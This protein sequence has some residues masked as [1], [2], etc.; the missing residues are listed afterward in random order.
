MWYWMAGFPA[1]TYV[2]TYRRDNRSV[3][4]QELNLPP[5]ARLELRE[6]LRWNALPDNRFY[7]YDYYKDN[8]STRVRDAIDR[9][10]GGAIAAHTASLPTGKSYR[11]HT[12]RLTANDPPIFTGL[13][14]ALGPA[15]DRPISAWE[16]MFLPMALRDHVRRVT[17]Q[18]PDGARVPL[19]ASERTLFISTAPQPPDAPPSW[20]QWY[21]LIGTSLGA[22]GALLGDA[23]QRRR[24]AR[25][26]LGVL[27]LLWGTIAGLAGVVLAV[28]WGFTD[29]VMAYRNENLFQLNPLVLVLAAL[30]PLGLAGWRRM[31]RWARM[32]ALGVAA[33]SAAGFV[34]QA[35][36]G[37]D[38]V[39]GQVIAL[40]LPVHLG[41]ALG[42]RRAFQAPG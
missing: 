23:A 6:F 14:L 12:Q 40:A 8:C 3:W 35:L 9:V 22:L 25:V 16:E 37:F 31:A 19:V 24:G 15:V 42:V 33:L 38:Q 36:P 39:N 5:L 10:I 21:L 1:E 7:H 11:F 30:V 26:A 17:V 28:L 18:G 20:L 13:L 34:L 4:L 29:H 41:L 32:T 27:A 2:R